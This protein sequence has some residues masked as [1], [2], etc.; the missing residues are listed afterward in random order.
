MS[1]KSLTRAAVVL[2]LLVAAFLMHKLVFLLLMVAGAGAG[3]GL[4][5]VYVMRRDRKLRERRR[6]E[7]RDS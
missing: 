7:N 6:L 2:A 5:F 4:G 1:T 3:T